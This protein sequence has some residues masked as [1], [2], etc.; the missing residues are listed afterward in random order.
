MLRMCIM[1]VTS[2]RH[3]SRTVDSFIWRRSSTDAN[4]DILGGCLNDLLLLRGVDR[5]I[6][7]GGGGG[8]EQWGSSSAITRL[9]EWCQTVI[10]RDGFFYLPLTPMIDS[11][12]CTPFIPERRFLSHSKCWRFCNGLTVTFNDAI[13]FSDINLNDGVRDVH[14]NQCMSNTWEFSIFIL[15]WV[16]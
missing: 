16:G 11:F 14:Y 3:M 12:S 8:G 7:G 9:A 1:C 15:S 13:T 4:T 5:K 10:A 6:R 2:A